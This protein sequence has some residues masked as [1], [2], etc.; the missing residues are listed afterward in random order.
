MDLRVTGW[1]CVDWIG[2][3]WLRTGTNGRL[4]WTR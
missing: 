2:C 3:I 4:L 1:E